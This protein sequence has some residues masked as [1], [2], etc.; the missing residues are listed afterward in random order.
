MSDKKIIVKKPVVVHRMIESPVKK[1]Q[2]K[3]EK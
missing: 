2:I 3:R 1:I